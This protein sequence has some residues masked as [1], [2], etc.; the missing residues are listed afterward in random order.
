MD[1]GQIEDIVKES[2][3][4]YMMHALRTAVCMIVLTAQCSLIIVLVLCCMR[5][6]A[7]ACLC[8]FM[9]VAQ[10]KVAPNAPYLIIIFMMIIAIIIQAHKMHSD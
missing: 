8:V 7:L 1:M 6:H 2:Q 5:V 4:L 10:K 9:C 3:R